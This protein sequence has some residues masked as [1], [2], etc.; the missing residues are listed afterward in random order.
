MNIFNHTKLLATVLTAMAASALFCS[1]EQP[2]HLQPAAN[3][4]VIALLG[5]ND[6]VNPVEATPPL[7]REQI[8]AGWK[9]ISVL[10]NFAGF[11]H[12]SDLTKELEVRSG[13]NIYLEPR[14]ESRLVL[15][16]ASR[17]DL[18]EVSDLAGDW[19][20]VTFRKPIIGF[21]RV[22]DGE[23]AA[24][25]ILPPPPVEMETAVFTDEPPPPARPREQRP[26]TSGEQ[27]T[28]ID[29]TLRI[30]EGRVTRARSWIGQSPPYSHQ[31]LDRSGRRIAYLD[32]SRLL[33]TEPL[34]RAMAGTLLVYGKAESIPDRRDFVI[35]VEHMRTH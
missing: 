14:R 28:T 9:A 4:P 17:N 2:V 22:T 18:F 7:T 33:I 20:S 8:Q 5:E 25:P 30:F 31:L 26:V 13:A 32:L 23:P 10:Q 29:G 16:E 3:A 6:P 21:I 11:V 12:R 35:R 27:L 1:G 15:T 19:A 34:E 24:L